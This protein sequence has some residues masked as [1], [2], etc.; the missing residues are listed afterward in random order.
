MKNQPTKKNKPKLERCGN[1]NHALYDARSGGCPQCR[2]EK[3]K[4]KKSPDGLSL[5]VLS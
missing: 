3:G 4:S 1:P 2:K 5:K